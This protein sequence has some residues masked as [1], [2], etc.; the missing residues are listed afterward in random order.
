MNTAANVIGDRR[1]RQ[2]IGGIIGDRVNTDE[3]GTSSAFQPFGFPSFRAR[4]LFD[5]SIAYVIAS[6]FWNNGLN[7]DALISPRMTL[8]DFFR[9]S[10]HY[11]RA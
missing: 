4:H 11:G 2:S 5:F 8:T 1:W 7:S 6:A 9:I 3:M 10:A